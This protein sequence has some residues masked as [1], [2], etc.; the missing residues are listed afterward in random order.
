MS[1][2][3]SPATASTPYLHAEFRA[4]LIEV[5]ERRGLDDHAVAALAAPL[6]GAVTSNMV[7]KIRNAEPFRRVDIDEAFAIA[8]GLGYESIA[9]LLYQAVPA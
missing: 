7:W 5:M 3:R 2:R 6:Y 1:P 8:R 4:R 9:A